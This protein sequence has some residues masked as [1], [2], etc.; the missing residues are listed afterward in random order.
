MYISVHLRHRIVYWVVEQ[1][2]N[3]IGNRGKI[4]GGGNSVTQ[5]RAPRQSYVDTITRLGRNIGQCLEQ[6]SVEK[7]IHLLYGAGFIGCTEFE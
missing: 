7:Q 5:V 2:C 3:A 6:S 4:G 1:G